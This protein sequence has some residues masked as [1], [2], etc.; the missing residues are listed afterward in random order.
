MLKN[1]RAERKSFMPKLFTIFT[2]V[3]NPN[4]AGRDLAGILE[5]CGA[6][7]WES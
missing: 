3:H 2:A 5:F 6:H 7:A 1:F 4:G